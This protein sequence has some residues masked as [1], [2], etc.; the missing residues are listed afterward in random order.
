MVK[1]NISQEFRLEN[2]EEIKSCS[3]KKQFKMNR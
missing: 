2:I 1:G 3:L